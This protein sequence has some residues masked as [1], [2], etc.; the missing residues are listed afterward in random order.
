M[1]ANSL[2]VHSHPTELLTFI[3]E[4]DQ[5]NVHVINSAVFNGGFLVG[6]DF[7]NYQRVDKETVFGKQLL[8]WR[9]QF[10]ELCREHDIKPAKASLNFGLHVPGVKSIAVSSSN[11]ER[12]KETI[13]MATDMVPTAFWQSMLQH[14]L[15]A[16]DPML[17][18]GI[19][20]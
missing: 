6:S 16:N 19:R 5:R 2:T 12:L 20:A 4:L 15:I 13:N 3:K 8:Q 9:E 7:Y 10:Y 17:L 1:I 11:P 18:N 14:G